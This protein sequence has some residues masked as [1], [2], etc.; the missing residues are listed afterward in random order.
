M[1]YQVS[2]Q[3]DIVDQGVF[4]VAGPRRVQVEMLASGRHRTLDV[5]TQVH[6]LVDSGD[7]AMDFKL[8]ACE[9][10][11][12]FGDTLQLTETFQL[13]LC[14]VDGPHTN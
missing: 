1:R 8:E 7:V 2:R 6:A 12:K 14:L 9:V 4:A 11:E 5:T 10:I 13:S 3:G